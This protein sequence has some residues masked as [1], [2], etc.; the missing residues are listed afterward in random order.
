M[1]A[2]FLIARRE[3]RGYLR[4]MTGWIIAASVLLIDGLLFNAFALEGQR[5]STEV[6]TRF[7]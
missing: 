7:F 1:S 6:L 2:V 3:L 4:T 5:R